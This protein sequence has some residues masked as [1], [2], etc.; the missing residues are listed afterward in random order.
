M[1]L[2][3][4]RNP[5]VSGVSPP[6]PPGSRRSRLGHFARRLM[7]VAAA[8]L[9]VVHFVPLPRAAAFE[10]TTYSSTW[11][12]SNYEGGS[13]FPSRIAR[14]F[15]GLWLQQSVA[16]HAFYSHPI[17]EG[18][19]DAQRIAARLSRLKPM[20]ISQTELMHHPPNSPTIFAGFGW[21]DGINAFAAIVL[22][23]E[24]PSAEIIGVVDPI[25][26]GGHSFGRVWSDDYDDWL[27]FDMWT[28][29]VVVFRSR[30]GKPAEYLSRTRP[31]GQRSLPAEDLPLFR[32][33]YDNAHSGFVHNRLQ[34]SLGGYVFSR[35][36]NAIFHGSRFPAGADEAI[37][38]AVS[39]TLPTN[40]PSD[41]PNRTVA[42][43]AYLHARLDHLTGNLAG[44]R[45]HYM[46]VLETEKR[47]LSMY[48][49]AA[50]IFV[51]RI[52]SARRVSTRAPAIT[53]PGLKSVDPKP[54]PNHSAAPLPGPLS[55]QDLAMQGRNEPGIF[56]REKKPAAGQDAARIGK[57]AG[58]SSAA[59]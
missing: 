40:F 38:V 26:R 34:P 17:A 1:L 35:I 31:L 18:T 30:P 8:L 48:G 7:V 59:L 16:T 44:A 37:A 10:L 36:G 25:A 45:A 58:P 55:P 5:S 28:D 12:L 21:C 24:F 57:G 19:G 46:E 23:H 52:D 54:G 6:P 11:L 41:R 51:T 15:L 56:G 32:R 43:E 50:R 14:K 3:P 42:S 9:G 2:R 20:M 27:Y 49:R 39:S 13:S 4:R 33:T 22:S 29:E 47:H 53:A